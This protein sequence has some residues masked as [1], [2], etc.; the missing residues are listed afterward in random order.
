VIP[1]VIDEETTGHVPAAM[2]EELTN[3][4]QQR[5]IGEGI[6]LLRQEYPR[7]QQLK[8]NQKHAGWA[9]GCLAQWIDI[10]FVD[11]G[12]LLQV[13]ARFDHGA[14]H[15][16]LLGDYLH[17]KL[18]EALAAMR[19]EELIT[20][21][22]HLD[23]VM[24]LGAET[25]DTRTALIATL[26]KARCLRKAG[27]YRQALDVTR[28]G[29]RVAAQ[30]G[31]S[32]MKA[33]MQTLESWIVFQDGQAKEAIRIL[34]E[35]EAV[36]R[37]T[38]DFITLG[39]I[40]SA[41]GRIALREGRYNHAMQ[42]FEA[43]VEYFK[44]RDSLLGYRA[45]SLTNMAQAKRFLA[46]QLRRSIDARWE[47]QRRQKT[48]G[49]R[50]ESKSKAAQLERMYELLRSAQADLAEADRI[51]KASQNHHGA[52]NT[53]VSLAQI[54]LDLGHLEQ[55][56]ERA[57]EAFDLGAS[58]ADYVLLCRARIVQATV[59]NARYEDEVGEGEDSSHFAQLA[60]DCSKEAIDY[61]ERTQNRR[62]LA[63]AHISHGLTLV[64]GF[65]SQADAARACCDR[66]E[67]YLDHDRHDALWGEVEILRE[68]IS[69]GGVEDP[70]LRAWS[71]GSVG[72]KSLQDVVGQFEEML[73]RKVWEHEGRKVS[74]V[75]SRLAVSPKKVRRILR[76]LGVL[77]ESASGSEDS[78]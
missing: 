61:G 39:N 32:P 36:L 22:G 57:N 24:A 16:L 58:K 7:F 19:A 69:H 45:R 21:I 41:Y 40:Q 34:Q 54:Y 33:V 78:D 52:G 28:Q 51:Y 38:D 60:H 8:P 17:L 75:A 62:L 6:E 70:N 26:W 37:E 72:D 15:Q 64:N 4:M 48:A 42:Y 68:R 55:A 47:R 25:G 73:V 71:Q 53:D 74:R 76:H 13:L 23:L 1:A 67:T 63:Q 59:A 35:A 65:F 2:L 12:V 14:K 9:I 31:L 46:L 5:R 56:E 11:D 77:L 30:L 43:S 10:G 49:E 18:A 29:M 20:A 50:G 3:C 66:A 27:E 44:H